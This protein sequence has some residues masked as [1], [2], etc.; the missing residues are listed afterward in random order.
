MRTCRVARSTNNHHHDHTTM[1]DNQ[2]DVEAQLRI[3]GLGDLEGDE[4]TLSQ[5]ALDRITGIARSDLRDRYTD[6]G[7]A[8]TIHI[9]CINAPNIAILR[10]SE[11]ED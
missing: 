5:D 3:G 4:R 2:I 6:L 8:D 7:D 11:V 9:L 10:E 1:V